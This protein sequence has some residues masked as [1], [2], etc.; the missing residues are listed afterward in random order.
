MGTNSTIEWTDHTFNPWIGCTRVSPACEHCY[1]ESMANHYGWATWG[2]AGARGT[3]HVTSED[4]WKKPVVWNRE[5]QRAGTRAR[6]FCASLADV[7]ESFAGLTDAGTTLDAER[8]RLWQLVEAT[9][10]LDWLLLT[11]R[12]QDIHRMIPRAWRK[13]MPPNVWLGTTVENQK[14]LL[15]RNP[16][17]RFLSV[18]PQLGAVDLRGYLPR[19]DWVIGGG[20]S[21]G[22]ARPTAVDCAR[23]S[24]DQCVAAGVPFFFKQWGNHAQVGQ[25]QG[26]VRL[27]TPHERALDGRIWDQLPAAGAR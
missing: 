5:A 10:H 3:R 11:K 6:V 20:E 26:L 13:A 21:G 1:A 24:R 22:G 18:E 16:A 23:D 8:G 27:R 2:T 12:P 25:S 19:L 14:Y 7:F 4:N 15:K 9:E 17:V